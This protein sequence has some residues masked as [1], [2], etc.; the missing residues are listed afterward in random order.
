MKLC[1]QHTFAQIVM[2]G[3]LEAGATF[4]L[5]ILCPRH[6]RQRATTILRRITRQALL[7]R[8]EQRKP[9]EG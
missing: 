8:A 4:G 6:A 9:K 2:A 1:Q 3:P 5:W 7:R